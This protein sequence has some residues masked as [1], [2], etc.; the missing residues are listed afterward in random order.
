[1]IT[2]EKEFNAFGSLP[3]IIVNNINAKIAHQLTLVHC[4]EVFNATVTV[5]MQKSDQ[6]QPIPPALVAARTGT[7]RFIGLASR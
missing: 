5:A 4:A 3:E 7:C 6:S 2:S 1:L